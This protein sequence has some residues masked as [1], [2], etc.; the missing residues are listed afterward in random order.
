MR[1]RLARHVPSG[2]QACPRRCPGPFL[3][4]RAGIHV[5]VAGPL[6]ALA[7]RAYPTKPDIFP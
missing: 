1:P 4:R 3:P 7:G 6:L 2:A 5:A